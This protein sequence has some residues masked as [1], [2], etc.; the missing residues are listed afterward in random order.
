M[1]WALKYFTLTTF[2]VLYNTAPILTLFFSACFLRE[3]VVCMDYITVILGFMA[4]VTIIYGIF[5]QKTKDSNYANGLVFAKTDHFDIVAFVCLVSTPIFASL[6]T[7]ILRRLRKINENTLS[8][9]SNI[10]AAFFGLLIIYASGQG[11]DFAT[12][13][14]KERPFTMILFIITGSITAP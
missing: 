8:C 5:V 9:Y 11:T 2:A 10:S 6:N 3:K 14:L 1:F 4:V 7:I 12:R 13:I